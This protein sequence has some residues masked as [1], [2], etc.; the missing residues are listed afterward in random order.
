MA[1]S[2]PVPSITPAVFRQLHVKLPTETFREILPQKW[3]DDHPNQDKTK[4]DEWL[5]AHPKGFLLMHSLRDNYPDGRNLLTLLLESIDTNV[6]IVNKRFPR[7][8]PKFRD[9]DLREYDMR[10]AYQTPNPNELRFSTLDDHRVDAKLPSAPYF[11]T[12][13]AYGFPRGKSHGPDRSDMFSLYFRYYNGGTLTNLSEMY[14]DPLIGAPIPEPFIW[15]V[16]DQLGRAV[17]SLRRGCSNNFIEKNLG[18]DRLLKLSCAPDGNNTHPFDQWDKDW[19]PVVHLDITERNVLLHFPED[20]EP[21]S[22]CFPQIV[23]EGFKHASVLDDLKGTAMELEWED[24]YM[25]GELLCRLVTNHD[26]PDEDPSHTPDESAAVIARML[27]KYLP[28]NLNLADGQK[29]AYSKELIT[30]LQRW[31]RLRPS[32]NPLN[33][34]QDGTVNVPDPEH[35]FFEVLSLARKK[36]ELYRRMGY[37][38]LAKEDGDGYMAD[39]SW[40]KPDPSFAHIPYA[41]GDGKEEKML[42]TLARELKWLFGPYIPVWY[43]YDGI[44]V[45]AIPPEAEEFYTITEREGGDGQTAGRGQGKHH[46]SRLNRRLRV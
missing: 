25:L 41:V 16:M 39:V 22:R 8:L 30:L 46:Q 20:G 3:L 7:L 36:T 34:D 27:P 26:A 2:N 45:S 44:D 11:P 37:D 32:A 13:Y 1:N 31:A 43:R 17:L 12:L 15:H 5:D 24:L 40:V 23:L 19:K 28:E 29:P 35:F 21:L 14:R 6:L 9:D 38:D 4:S 42:Q 18:V 10:V 33:Q